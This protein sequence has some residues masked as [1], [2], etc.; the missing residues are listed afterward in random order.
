MSYNLLNPNS[1]DHA[2]FATSAESEKIRSMVTSIVGLEKSTR[3]QFTGGVS[4]E[5]LADTRISGSFDRSNVAVMEQ[6]AHSLESSLKDSQFFISTE[7]FESSEAVGG[8]KVKKGM[9]ANVV[10][11][12]ESMLIGQNPAAFVKRATG[13]RN[14]PSR[15]LEGFKIGDAPRSVPR[16]KEASVENYDNKE[17]NNLVAYTTLFNMNAYTQDAYNRGF[18]Q[19]IAIPTSS[20]GLAVSINVMRVISDEVYALNT[21]PQDY[22]GGKRLQMAKIDPEI[23][24]YE[25]LRLFP[26]WSDGT[27]G[28]PSTE[29]DLVDPSL[30]PL[31]D[32]S[33]N[34]VAYK[35]QFIKAGR[36]VKLTA[37]GQ[38]PGLVKAGAMDL[39][40]AL[41]TNVQVEQLAFTFGRDNNVIFDKLDEYQW[42]GFTD[43]T[44]GDER[45][46]VLNFV[47]TSQRLDKDTKTATGAA[48]TG[49]VL[50]AIATN[51]WRVYFRINVSGRV[52]LATGDADVNVTSISVDRILDKTGAEVDLVANAQAKAI[53]DLVYSNDTALLGWMPLARL[54]NSNRRQRGKLIHVSRYGLQYMVPLRSPITALRPMTSAGDEDEVMLQALIAATRTM[55]NNDAQQKVFDTAKMLESI[56]KGFETEATMDGVEFMGVGRELLARPWFEHAVVKLEN[57]LNNIKASEKVNDIRATLLN[58]VRDMGYRAFMM[59]GLGIAIDLLY[60]NE[61][62]KPKIT[63]GCDQ[64]V[65]QYLM[66]AAE[67]RIGGVM[68]DMEIV[69]STL[70]EHRGK[71]YCAFTSNATNENVLD[72]L[73]F[74]F[75]AT[76]P[77]LVV[78]LP[79]MRD[80]KASYELTVQ[81]SYMFGVNV[82]VMWTLE[83]SDISQMIAK[84]TPIDV[85]TKAKP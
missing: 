41:D 50:E 78:N 22:W 24:R 77:E 14:F 62:Y 55:I 70:E 54:T 1:A 81:P 71:I 48:L 84:R 13:T 8:V 59:S 21:P 6:L 23:L 36:R 44:N 31:G 2:E 45:D 29:A 28:T 69:V 63:V 39:T 46:M 65:A 53:V 72:V 60:G 3:S 43:T 37:L 33:E 47:N 57:A 61:S 80:G 85:L 35:T 34:G 38:R 32:R 79:F 5:S 7:N 12:I 64:Y 67:V 20:A 19:H 16:I 82:P 42:S 68:F 49:T 51:E 74:G 73:N 10:M 26:V 83:V 15:V 58:K 18:F 17:N 4:M 75:M 66:E 40:D 27:G 56:C 30:I 9:S 25:T 52:N 11:G 76:Q